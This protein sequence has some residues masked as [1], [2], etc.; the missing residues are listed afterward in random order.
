M[1]QDGRNDIV[2]SDD[3][4]V[5]CRGRVLGAVIIL[6]VLIL[7]ATAI[8][9]YTLFTQPPQQPV[10]KAAADPPSIQLAGHSALMRGSDLRPSISS[11]SAHTIASARS[12]ERPG[13]A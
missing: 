8:L 12:G 6:A 5:G 1:D 4:V 11:L 13:P 7:V 2:I 10:R 9:F 3:R